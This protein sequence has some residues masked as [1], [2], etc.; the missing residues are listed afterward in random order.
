VFKFLDWFEIWLFNFLRRLLVVVALLALCF[1]VINVFSG[2]SKLVDV[3]DVSEDDA[4]EQ[5]AFSDFEPEEPVDGDEGSVAGAD[6]EDSSVGDR[7]DSGEKEV[8]DPRVKQIVA[9][10]ASVG[11]VFEAEAFSS[12][13]EERVP[14]DRRNEFLDGLVAWAADVAGYYKEK[15]WEDGSYY[16]EV[17]ASLDTYIEVFS[18]RL[19][20]L[21]DEAKLAKEEAEA[22]NSMAL[23]QLLLSLYG[24][25][26]VVCIIV[27]L[28]AFRVEVSLRH[29]KEL[30]K[31]E[32]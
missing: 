22:N 7:E 12:W 25:A 16:D 18:E 9:S 26:V 2:T 21:A 4:L 14:R 20:Q 5:V 19:R 10:Y 15:E 28:I 17:A 32:G 8:L 24:L 27:F 13:V 1:A 6:G 23:P 3:P 11:N 30:K 31:S 29:L